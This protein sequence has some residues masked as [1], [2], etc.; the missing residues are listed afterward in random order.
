MYPLSAAPLAGTSSQTPCP[1]QHLPGPTTQVSYPVGVGTI[2]GAYAFD[3][4]PGL[5]CL[6]SNS[7]NLKTFQFKITEQLS[8]SK[9]LLS[10]P[11]LLQSLVVGQTPELIYIS[12]LRVH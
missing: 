6:K 12:L 8:L 7:N 2:Y 10:G 11:A 4:Q 3:L 1:S 5:P 9:W